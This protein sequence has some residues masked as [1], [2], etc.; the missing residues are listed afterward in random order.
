MYW[1]LR[2]RAITIL[3]LC[4]LAQPALAGLADDQYAVAAHHYAKARW[5]LAIEEFTQFLE[6]YPDHDRADSVVFFLAE[7]LVQVERYQA[8]HARFSEYLERSPEGKYER[9]S[10]FRVGETLY[11]D[12]KHREARGFLEQFV[13]T[14]PEDELCEYAYPYLGEIGLAEGDP[15]AAQRA[16]ERG[17]KQFPDGALSQECRF[18]LARSLE[19]LD[20]AEGAIRFYEFLGGSERRTA[21]SDDAL[22]QLGI[23]LYHQG[24]FEE[25]IAALQRKREQYPG[26]DLA[27][28]VAYWLGI[29]QTERGRFQKAVE[30]LTAATSRFEDHEL[31]PALV[32]ATGEAHHKMGD[33]PEAER[34]Y[35]RVMEQYPDSK[36]T[37]DSLRALIQVAWE[38]EDHAGV[39]ELA[40]RFAQEHEG[41]PLLP[42]VQQ[43]SARVYLKQAE[44]ERAIALLR[45]SLDAV[46]EEE[47]KA[48][49][50]APRT[51]PS[52]SS[53]P[54][55][56]ESGV[57]AA[58]ARYYLALA[59][60]GAERYTE[61]LEQF[62]ALADAR[63]PRELV[64]GVRM[65]RASALLELERYEEAVEPLRQYLEARPDGPEA[66]K[67]RAQLAVTSARLDRWDDVKRLFLQMKER[68]AGHEA[69]LS[70]LEYLAEAAY[71]K[72][73]KKLAESMFRELAQD[74][75]PERYVMRGMSG[76]AW[77]DWTR[78][79]ET[80]R[81]ARRFEQLLERFP[82]SP[83]AA[84]AAMMRGRALEKDNK[85]EGALAMYRLVRD[86]YA[87]SPHVSS[88][89]LA[90]ARI[91]DGLEQDRAAEPLLREWLEQYPSSDQRPSALYRLAWVL[92]DLQRE[93]EADGVFRQLHQECRSSRYWSDATYRLAERA[94]RNEQ[95]EEADALAREII[96]EAKDAKMVAHSLYLRG[97][98]A[99]ANKRWK[100]AVEP[101]QRLVKEYPDSSQRLP[102][103]YWLAEAYYRR[104]EY[105]KA[106]KLFEKLH[107]QTRDRGEAWVAMIPLRHAQGLA[108]QGRWEE[109][110][111]VASQIRARF[112]D[113]SQQH[114]V[115]YLLGRYHASRA[116]FSESRAAYLRVIQSE[117]GRASET[118]AVAQ[119]MIGETYFMQEQYDQAIKAYYRVEGL[120]DFARWKAAALLQAG[121]CHEM[122]GRWNEAIESYSQVLEHY[123]DTRFAE[124]ANKRLHVARQE[125]GPSQ[126]R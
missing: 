12:G 6:D 107:E 2:L 35:Q 103:E 71:D 72:D 30:T 93:E 17:L 124:K 42:L 85:P 24:R 98:L 69:Y 120:Y 40:E 11:L 55:Q 38:T 5:E 102:A 22:L 96:E 51:D 47:T 27:P 118:A 14:Y 64:D 100:D 25:A 121:K 41:S 3:L 97:Q 77:L 99:A 109:A 20:D 90:A 53:M 16:F 115:D 65:A 126:T 33:F 105:G 15:E 56:I 87:D 10:R 110:F 48:A 76:L 104:H 117:T 1:I 36:W 8:A 49:P 57:T 116:E 19:Q 95:Y 74:G 7:S 58:S 78:E 63:T 75:N 26:G 18:G 80:S 86:R 59:L 29:S 62:D 13:A 114:E 125:A 39:N 106:G 70:A 108:R 4:G 9:Q 113:F 52:A 32:F 119:W 81:S 84:E 46:L 54:R 28:H 123:A 101:L 82:E 83:L 92:V 111:D 61:A 66:G 73:R 67:C 31:G 23:L 91:H 50:S 68:H 94:A 21:I 89:T 122:L 88:A 79:D 45:P 112:P 37:D 44:Y 43:M 34:F 60:L